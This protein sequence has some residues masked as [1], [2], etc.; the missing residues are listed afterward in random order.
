MPKEFAEFPTTRIIIDCTEI[1]VEVPS[2]MLAQSQTCFNYKHH[3]TYKVL[4]AVAPIGNVTFVSDLWGDSVSDKEI[5]KQSGLIDM[6]ESGD[7]V[8]VDRGFEIQDI[9]PND[10]TLNIPPFKRDKQ[11]LTPEA[12]EKTMNI[13]S[14]RI[15][16]ERA[17]G[18]IKNYHILDGVLP[19]SLSCCKLNFQSCC[20]I[21]KLFATI[22]SAWEI[23]LLT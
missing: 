10:I 8:M 20:I 3:N 16:V 4:V 5:T 6:L 12:V 11:H 2:A 19:L 22:G 15:H 23:K 17:I 21:D 9:L 1:F 14:V 13:A 18:R 7:N